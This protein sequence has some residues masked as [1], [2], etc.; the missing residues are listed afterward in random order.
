M[1]RAGPLTVDR[2]SGR[3]LIYVPKA[4]VSIAGTTQPE[5]LAL[6]L[7]GRYEGE[8][9]TR[10][11]FANGLAARLLMVYPP[12]IPKRW[13]DADLPVEIVQAVDDVFE[14]LLSLDLPMDE[15][16]RI[17]PVAIPLTV[18]AQRRFVEFYNDHSEEQVTLGPDLAAAWSKLEGYAARFA[19]LV[20]L[21]RDAAGDRTLSDPAAVDLQSLDAGITLSRWF[22][23]EAARIYATIGGTGDNADSRQAR[24]RS[25]LVEWI[26]SQGGTV[27][28]RDVMRSS[29]KYGTAEEAEEALQGLADAGV[30]VFDVSQP[31]HGPGRPV[32][33]FTLTDAVDVDTNSGNPRKT[34]IVS[35]SAPSTCPESEVVSAA[36]DDWEE[37]VV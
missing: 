16:G 23:D 22:G 25:R 8:E 4:A 20:H 26:R 37:F 36:A 35:T 30:G 7:G 33:R 1:H 18:E 6:A 15:H 13:T 11:H 5:I 12:R 32:R 14:R 21:V 19:L 3:R 27:T 9:D 31:E 28:S 24:G 2:K 34:A 29:R 10:E 17:Q